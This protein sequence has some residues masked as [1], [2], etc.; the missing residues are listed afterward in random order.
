MTDLLSSDAATQS[1]TWWAGTENAHDASRVLDGLFETESNTDHN[2]GDQWLEIDLGHDAAISQID[3]YNRFIDSSY[4]TMSFNNLLQDAVATVLDDGAEVWTSEGMTNAVLHSFEL[5]G[6]VGDTVRI[7][8]A[9]N[10]LHVSE[11]DV[12]GTYQPEVINITDTLSADAASQ[13][14]NWSD[15]NW[16]SAWA[17]DNDITTNHHTARND[18]APWFELDLRRSGH[19]R[20]APQRDK[21]NAASADECYAYAA[22]KDLGERQLSAVLSFRSFGT[23]RIN[24]QGL[25]RADNSK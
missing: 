2:Y 25:S 15:T 10:Y 4:G 16:V 14:S 8:G 21:R 5:E 22:S 19:P 9:N 13:S 24:W 1:T 17:I 11:V 20:P 12:F 23:S 7:E 3:V 6:I 18:A